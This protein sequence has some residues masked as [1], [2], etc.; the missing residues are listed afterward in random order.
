M[1][2]ITEELT[3]SIVPLASSLGIC[4]PISNPAAVTQEE[5]ISSTEV[6][7]EVVLK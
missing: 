7:Y 3:E 6:I 5:S 4:R 1:A 2:Q